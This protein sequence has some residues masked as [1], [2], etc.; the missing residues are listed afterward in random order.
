MSDTQKII[1]AMSAASYEDRREVLGKHL[2][3]LPYDTQVEVAGEVALHFAE[4][5]IGLIQAAAAAGGPAV[6][7][8]RTVIENHIVAAEVMGLDD[9]LD[10]LGNDGGNP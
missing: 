8:V 9:E 5:A 3:D 7:F 4:M 2:S 1:T 6:Q 10:A